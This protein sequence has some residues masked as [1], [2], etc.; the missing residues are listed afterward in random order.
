MTR[1]ESDVKRFH[2]EHHDIILKP[3][4]GMGGMGI[5]RVGPDGMNLG[6]IVETL[7]QGGATTLMVQ[8]YLPE[9]VQGDKRVL[10]NRRQAGAVFA[11]AHS[12]GQRDPRQPGRGWQ[13]RG[14]G[15]HGA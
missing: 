13:G 11:G 8:K 15:A 9:I 7:N 6:S 12:A 5:F 1:D 14:D 2:A 10:V 3:L 4:D